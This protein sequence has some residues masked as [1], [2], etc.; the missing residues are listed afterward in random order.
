[1]YDMI[2]LVLVAIIHGI[3]LSRSGRGE[4]G[5]RGGYEPSNS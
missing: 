4:G 1:M 2:D 3:D 5:G